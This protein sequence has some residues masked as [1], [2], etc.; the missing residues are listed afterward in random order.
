MVDFASMTTEELLK[1]LTELTESGNSGEEGSEY[2]RT[3][4]TPLM[5]ELEK[6]GVSVD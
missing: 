3:L 5:N 6:R 2:A 4:I 1:S